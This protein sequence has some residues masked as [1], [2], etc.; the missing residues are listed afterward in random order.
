MRHPAA[1]AVLLVGSLAACD[2]IL[3]QNPPDALPTEDAITDARGAR[4]ALA[5]A[6]DGLRGAD[7]FYYAAEFI[8][9]GDLSA[10]GVVSV[11]ISGP[12]DFAD[13][14]ELRANNS[15]VA[16]VWE[17]IY[18][19]LNRVNVI[20]EAVPGLTD[21][22]DAEKNQI[23]GEAH[24]LRA[25]NLHNLT[26]FWGDVPMPLVSPKSV[27]EA[28][29]ITRTPAAEVYA[30]IR[31]DLAEAE[32]LV[33]FGPDSTT[34]VST[35]L[36]DALQARVALYEGNWATAVAEADE[37]LAQG[38]QL[39]DDFTTL[40]DAEGTD[41]EEDILK[42]T[43]TAE[44]FAWH[45]F[46]YTSSDDG[47]EGTVG[48]SQHL[49]D[50][51]Q[52]DDVRGAWSIVGDTE[53]EASGHKFPTTIGA[54]DFHVIR[55][56]EVLLIKAEALARQNDLVGAVDA[57]NLIRER[58]G[59]DPHTLGNEVNSQAEVLAEIDLQR[60]LELAFE[61]DRWPDLVRSGRAV[62]VMGGIPAYQTLYPIPQTEI[63]VAPG[64]SQNPG[65]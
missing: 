26:K 11:G 62:E 27:E 16:G 13:A 46:Y 44:Q 14:N 51:Y 37:V 6:Y 8:T 5:G 4:A 12:F 48:P 29:Q 15:S 58:A 38:Y 17:D 52:P 18:E 10:D 50:L 61:G 42:L 54:E 41:T 21:L 19:A 64:V 23:L 45:G 20:L 47:G 43:F 24:A 40:F 39:A 33:A 55:L 2:S 31:A 63:D 59:L 65:Y 30:Q 53:G 9:L 22:D 1:F 3:D 28:S 60:Q 7:E 49:I 32:T 34:R 35:G 57:Y 36:V 25:L 56:A